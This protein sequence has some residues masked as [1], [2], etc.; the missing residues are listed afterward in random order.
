LPPGTGAW[1]HRDKAA[2]HMSA[3]RKS[4]EPGHQRKFL[5]VV[6][7][8]AECDRA[9]YYATRRAARTGGKLV[10]FA[11]VTVGE[12][13]Q[14]WLGVGDLMR[15]EAREEAKGRLEHDASRARNLAGI[16][17][18]QVL[19]EGDKADEILKYI[20]EDADIGILVLAAGTGKEGPGPLVSSIG[21][22]GSGTFPI[23]ITIVPGNLKDEDLDALA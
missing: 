13:G 22:A 2:D 10:L 19:R 9:V 4:F 7:E 12:E 16:D 5:V 3:I 20:E 14:Q 11:A 21:G 6:D 1:Q 18:E 15:E 17:P 8:T 23:P